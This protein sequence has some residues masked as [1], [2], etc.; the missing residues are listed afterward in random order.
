M[1]IWVESWAGHPVLLANGARSVCH[2]VAGG[3]GGFGLTAVLLLLPKE[4]LGG[5]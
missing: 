2:S 4:K 1:D 5:R 3:F